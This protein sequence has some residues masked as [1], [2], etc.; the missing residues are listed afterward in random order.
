MASAN[1]DDQGP[2]DESE[3]MPDQL[4]IG[5]QKD[6]HTNNAYVYTKQVIGSVTIHL[7]DKGSQYSR[8]GE[9]LL[10]RKEDDGSWVAWDSDITANKKTLL[11]RQ[12][13]FRCWAPN[14]TKPGRY[15]WEANVAASNTNDG[16]FVEWDIVYFVTADS[17]A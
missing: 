14:V 13:V 8:P 15:T 10:L 2:E 11:C 17:L 3:S 4:F 12:A 6:I 5:T 16:Y 1:A 9:I 7:C